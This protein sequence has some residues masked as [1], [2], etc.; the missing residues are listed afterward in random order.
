VASL[1]QSPSLPQAGP[2]VTSGALA[3]SG[4]TA[5]QVSG[6]VALSYVLSAPAMLEAT[7]LNMAGRPIAQVASS[8]V[9]AGGLQS[10]R[11]NGRNA[12]GAAVPAGTYLLQ[13]AANGADGASA[14]A[15]SAVSLSR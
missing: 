12:S 11:W 4:V 3:V 10:L 1:P 15:L 13:V 7:V 14:S 6:G 9:Q 8:D 5:Q 2:T